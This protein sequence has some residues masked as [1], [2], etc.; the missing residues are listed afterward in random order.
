[1]P[2]AV[3]KG[4]RPNKHHDLTIE[5]GDQPTDRPPPPPFSPPPIQNKTSD[6]DR[7]SIPPRLALRHL[8]CEHVLRQLFRLLSWT[9]VALNS[10]SLPF[11]RRRTPSTSPSSTP[12]PNII[13]IGCPVVCGNVIYT[14]CPACTPRSCPLYIY[15]VS[16]YCTQI[17]L[18]IVGNFILERLIRVGFGNQN[19]KKQTN[20]RQSTREDKTRR[21]KTKRKGKNTRT[22]KRKI[23]VHTRKSQTTSCR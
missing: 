12:R 4:G 6:T 20:K 14:S 17:Y 18:Y 13:I 22:D 23:N 2:P 15:V 21:D 8:Y 10:F 11:W 1:M 19:R 3:H 5:H 9:I 16:K 7:Q